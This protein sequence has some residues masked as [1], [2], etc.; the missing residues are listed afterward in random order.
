MMQPLSHLLIDWINTF[1][2]ITAFLTVVFRRFGN[3]VAC[4][5][6]QSIALALSMT[7]MGVAHHEK[8]LYYLALATLLFKGFFMPSWIDRFLRRIGARTEDRI[9]FS[10]A[11]S[12]FIAGGLLLGAHQVSRS[13]LAPHSAVIDD[14]TVCLTLLLAGFFFLLSRRHAMSQMMGILFMENG[15]TAAG[16]LLTTGMPLM[17]DLA[18]LF[19]VL[20]GVLVMGILVFRIQETFDT[21]DTNELRS[22]HG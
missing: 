15:V 22:L 5:R 2:L 21:G 13:V 20:I 18:V 14:L 12:L 16:V 6:A 19:D 9:F 11:A 8:H 1:L 4:Y 17:V 7:A 3:I 10:P